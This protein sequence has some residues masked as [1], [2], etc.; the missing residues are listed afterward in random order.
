MRISDKRLLKE[1]RAEFCTEFPFLGMAFFKDEVPTP[2]GSGLRV[3]D[4]R[5]YGSNGL[6]VLNGELTA[7]AIEQTMAEIFGLKTKVIYCEKLG[8]RHLPANRPLHE[9]NHHAM[10]LT[11]DVVI[12]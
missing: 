12:V 2:V 8:R 9:L 3:G 6:L 5:S 4:V 7:A 10:H 11:E 1:L